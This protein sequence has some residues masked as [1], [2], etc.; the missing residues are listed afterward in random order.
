LPNRRPG[1][2]DHGICGIQQI[3]VCPPRSG[4]GLEIQPGEH[5]AARCPPIDAPGP[6]D[7]QDSSRRAGPASQSGEN[8]RIDPSTGDRLDPPRTGVFQQEPAACRWR[9]TGQGIC[10][11]PRCVG[12]AE[13]SLWTIHSTMARPASSRRRARSRPRSPAFATPV[14]SKVLSGATSLSVSFISPARLRSRMSAPL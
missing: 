12:A 2:I 3:L 14:V 6:T 11:F 5:P 10:S 13:R 8:L 9:R 1:L 4:H 7:Q